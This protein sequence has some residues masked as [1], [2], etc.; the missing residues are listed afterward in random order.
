MVIVCQQIN[1]FH[2]ISQLVTNQKTAKNPSSD[3]R[4]V[5]ERTIEI[6]RDRI[7]F[8]RVASTCNDNYHRN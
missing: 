3:I 4:V 6:S 2:E 5:K 8:N 7:D 1:Y